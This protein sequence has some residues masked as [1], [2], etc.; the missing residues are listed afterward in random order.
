[1][2]HEAFICNGCC[3]ILKRGVVTWIC[4]NKSCPGNLYKNEKEGP[5]L[6]ECLT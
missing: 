6:N 4:Q 1:M 5:V 3:R 2:A